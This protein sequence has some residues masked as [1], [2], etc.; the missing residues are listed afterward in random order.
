MA[1]E[2]AI[3]PAGRIEERILVIRGQRVMLDADLAELYGTQTGA[4][5]RAVKRNKERFP[6]D[7]MFQ[8]SQ[9]EYDNLRCQIGTSSQW[10]GRR[11]APYAFTEHGAIM[12]AGVLNSERAV[13]V[14]VYVVR[15][16]VKLRQALA[17]H[18]ELGRK[19]AALE[20]RLDRHDEEIASLLEAI[21]ERMA[22]P[23]A[24]RRGRIGFRP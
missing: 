23:P 1:D 13:R 14:S 15:A 17:A 12:A 21:R 22:P 4:L 18:K 24:P 7:F 9:R 16:F 11:Y 8:L 19:L 6:T 3:L 10:G 2:N 20:G 5:V